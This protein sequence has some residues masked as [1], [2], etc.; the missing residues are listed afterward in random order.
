MMTNENTTEILKKI[1]FLEKSE[2]YKVKR[3]GHIFND[4]VNN[5]RDSISKEH[6][7]DL[8]YYMNISEKSLHDFRGMNI[9]AGNYNCSKIDKIG[10][11]FIQPLEKGMYSL[12]YALLAY[13]E[14]VENNSDKAIQYLQ[15]AIANSIEQS[16]TFGY[17]SITIGE[18]TL[19]KIRVYAKD[20][21]ADK[22]IS[23]SAKIINLFVFNI[24]QEDIKCRDKIMELD[25]GEKY[26]MI[27]HIINSTEVAL[28]KAFTYEEKLNI[29]KNIFS[30]VLMNTAEYTDFENLLWA[31]QVI[32]DIG[33]LTEEKWLENV[34]CSFYKLKYAPKSLQKIIV[35]TVIS[36]SKDRLQEFVVK[37]AFNENIKFLEVNLN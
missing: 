20:R 7:V 22:V 2:G 28:S 1:E 6:L 26:G 14:Y 13:K 25:T 23:E 4:L 35:Q 5:F 15:K 21:D 12:H 3:P 31:F 9:V 37:P 24:D 18:Q 30:Q 16:E 17:F 33:N 8:Y 10:S 27:Q 36:Y 32:S 34:N 19:N 29:L 11:L